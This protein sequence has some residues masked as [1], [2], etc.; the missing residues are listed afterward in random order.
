M[1]ALTILCAT[2]YACSPKMSE[3]IQEPTPQTTVQE[4]TSDLSPMSPELAAGQSIYG[5]KCS[6]CH[7]AKKITDYSAAQW[8]TILPEMTEA[9][10]L[11]EE[12]SSMVSAY[13]YWELGKP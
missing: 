1:T 11:N 3:I 6:T 7:S 13:V 5:N 12:E 2:L 10:K 8:S 9:A 4:P